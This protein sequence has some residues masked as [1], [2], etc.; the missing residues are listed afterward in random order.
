MRRKGPAAELKSLR[1]F[2]V[3]AEIKFLAPYLS[4]TELGTPS[5]TEELDVAA[6]VVLVHGALENYVEGIG[7][8]ALDAIENSWINGRRSSVAL[9]S[10]LLY[11][12][13]S[14]SDLDTPITVFDDIRRSIKSAKEKMSSQI[15][16]NHAITMRNLR[17]LLRPVGIAVP[18]DPRLTASL[19]QL[20]AIRHH[21]AHQYR[22]GAKVPKFA[23][24]V[25][26]VSDDCLS[27]AEQLAKA[28]KSS[29][30]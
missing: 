12:E 27:L 13:I 9:V 1:R 24:D 23:V 14:L 8:W 15:Q 17:K 4:F 11:S 28:A 21:W 29:R 30:P 7:L 16:Q 2:V 3:G 6:F 26:Q 19:D 20:I 25:K 18:E 22:F 10:L 5:R